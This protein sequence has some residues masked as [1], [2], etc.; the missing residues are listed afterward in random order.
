MRLFQRAWHIAVNDVL[1]SDQE[2]GLACDFS[3]KKTLKP[4]PNT[5]SVKIY[6]LSKATREKLTNPKRASL[7]IEAGYVERLSQIY[8]GDV[9]AL[10]PGEIRGPDIVTELSSGDGGQEIQKAN[11]QIPIGAKTPNGTALTA[12]AK[13]LGVGLGNVPKVSAAL[14]SKGS[15]VFPRGTVLTGNVSR[16]LSDF[17]RSAGLEWSVQDGVIQIL[18][19]G[20]GLETNPYVLS[21]DSGMIGAPA[22]GSDGKVSVST[23]MI[24]ELRPGMRVMF[25][26]FAVNGVYRISEAEYQGSTHGNEWTI[27][28]SCEKPKVTP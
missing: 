17:C 6:N 2:T 10:S 24:P 18:D 14:A 12:I 15:A 21:S 28:L 9:R 23:L 5:A 19:L 20:K 4:D 1:I 13:A 7:R 8:L 22:I 3:V 26:T 16:V 27:K 11:L 25:E